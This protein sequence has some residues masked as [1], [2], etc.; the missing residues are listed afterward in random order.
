MGVMGVIDHE[1]WIM[2]GY[3]G[4]KCVIEY[5]FMVIQCCIERRHW[6]SEGEF[7]SGFGFGFG[8]REVSKPTDLSRWI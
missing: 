1:S 5:S 3:P 8:M 4:C 6:R 2:Y 7:G